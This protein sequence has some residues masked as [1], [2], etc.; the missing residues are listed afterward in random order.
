[1][2]E[3][4]NEGEGDQS[5][6]N[7]FGKKIQGLKDKIKEIEEKLREL[8]PKSSPAPI[9]SVRRIPDDNT[10]IINTLTERLD[11]LESSHDKTV[12]KLNDHDERIEKLEEDNETNK[13]KISN[14]NQDIGELKDQIPEKVDCDT[15]DQEIA[16]LK[17]LYN[18]LGSGEKVEIK[19]PPPPSS[20]GMSTKDANKMKEITNKIPEFEKSIKEILERLGSAERTIGNHDKSLKYH[21]KSIEE[22]LGKYLL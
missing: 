4:Q 18:Q 19:A 14:N 12:E 1:M 15:F 13:D 22:I 16:Y 2:V 10:H 20:S 8:R 9:E 3:L 7:E 11:N 21:D 5:I 17:E 6:H